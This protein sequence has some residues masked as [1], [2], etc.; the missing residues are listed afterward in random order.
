MKMAASMRNEC[1]G[2][3]ANISGDIGVDV[4]VDD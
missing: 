2:I 3:A 1:C 4:D